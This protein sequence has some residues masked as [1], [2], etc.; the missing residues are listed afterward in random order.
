MEAL[1][2]NK[3][4]IAIGEAKGIGLITSDNINEAMESNFGDIGLKLLS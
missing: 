2:M 1:L 4:V 3:P